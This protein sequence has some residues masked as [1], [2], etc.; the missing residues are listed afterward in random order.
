MKRV[1]VTL[2]CF[3]MMGSMVA[4]EQHMTFVGV[5]I[6]GTLSEYIEEMESKG[7]SYEGMEEGIAT[8]KGD[9]AGY[10]NCLIT[11]T[12]LRNCDVVSKIAVRFPEIHHWYDLIPEYEKIK[13]LLTEKY[14]QPTKCTEKF[15]DYKGDS[16][17]Q[18]LIELSNNRV[19]WFTVFSTD[20]GEVE[21]TLTTGQFPIQSHVLLNYFDKENSKK[22]EKSAMEDL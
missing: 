5:P 4:Q 18:K 19:R 9:F 17:Y 20:L 2:V 6:D 7:F 8:L 13:S 11:V 14:G 10:K 22:V 3:L 15:L 1:L 12:T 21:L 16:D